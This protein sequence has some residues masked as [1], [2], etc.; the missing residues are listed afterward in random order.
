MALMRASPLLHTPAA[1]T[2]HAI[3][4]SHFTHLTHVVSAIFPPSSS[5]TTL[6]GTTLMQR[7]SSTSHWS[8][9]F[10]FLSHLTPSQYLQTISSAISSERVRNDAD[11]FTPR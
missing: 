11:D 8:E 7:N 3:L 10:P 4:S 5:R 1:I 6:C 2:L 9:P